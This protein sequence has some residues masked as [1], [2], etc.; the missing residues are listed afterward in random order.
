MDR[1]KKKEQ[2]LND[3]SIYKPNQILNIKIHVS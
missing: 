2:N 1:A 3:T